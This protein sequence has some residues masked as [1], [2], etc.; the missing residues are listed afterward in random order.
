MQQQP[1]SAKSMSQTSLSNH[2]GNTETADSNCI[3]PDIDTKASPVSF[4]THAALSTQERLDIKAEI[5]IEQ[6]KGRPIV[7]E[8]TKDGII[9]VDCLYTFFACC[10]SAIYVLSKVEIM[11]QFHIQETKAALSL[12]LYI[13]AYNLGPLLWSPLSE[14][15][16]FS[17]NIPYI[18]TFFIFV[19]LCIPTAFVDDLAGLLVFHFLQGFFGSPCLA[20]GGALMQDM[21][22]AL[23]EILW[24]STPTFGLMFFFL[25]ETSADNILLRR[26]RRL[27]KLTGNA[28]IQSQSE[29]NQ[30]DLKFSAV[31]FGALIKPVE[32]MIPRCF[33]PTSTPRSSTGS[34]TLSLRCSP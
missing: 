16:L 12:T 3:E 17:R 7:P 14:L 18:T 10:G 25:P 20:S 2:K 1:Q 15:P 34:I 9:L 19:V 26:A 5:A 6:T 32:I 24:M 8:R 13:I 29:I 4:R 22:W 11:L 21:R 23:W 30:R 33:S 31:L 27:C 28:N